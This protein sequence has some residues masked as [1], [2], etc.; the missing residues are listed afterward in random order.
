[1][2][3][4]Y[5]VVAGG[6]TAGHVNPALAIAE[7]LVAKGHDK[8]SIIFV[9]S[10]RGLE[11]RLVPEAGYEFIGLS[12]RGIVR[13][14]GLSA[15]KA[16]VGL[17]RAL[18]T[19]VSLMSKRKPAVVVSVGGYASA[20]CAIAAVLLRVPLVLA[21][22]NVH[23]GAANRLVARF[24]KVS[25]VSLPGTPLPRAVVTGNPVRAEFTTLDT[26]PAAVAR[27][28]SELGLPADRV[29]IAAFG[30][31]LGARSI[32]RAVVDLAERWA[33]RDITIYHVLGSRDW[34]DAGEARFSSVGALLYTATEYESHM[35]TLFS[36]ADVLICRS[37]ATTVAEIAA[38]GR[39]AVFVP[40]PGATGDHQS[41]NARALELAGAAVVVKDDQCTGE[42]LAEVLEPIVASAEKR[43][44]MAAAAKLLGIPDAADR[45]A[46]LVESHARSGK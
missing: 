20:P 42:R 30:G 27:A 17:L 13:R 3:S 39:P 21:E 45:V 6:G 1:M 35:V 8:S 40:F 34:N 4:T 23:P 31:S 25:A 26:S 7:A 24:A 32:N 37:G 15:L 29:V 33:D 2:S 36:A 38:A 46:G 43:E 22:S 16:I 18:V 11:A 19:A 14:I 9:G 12:G 28:K 10:R 5:A 41:A 44:G